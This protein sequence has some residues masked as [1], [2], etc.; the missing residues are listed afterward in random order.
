MPDQNH[1]PPKYRP[2]PK[3]IKKRE[4]IEDW[5]NFCPYCDN[6]QSDRFLYYEP[7][8]PFFGFNEGKGTSEDFREDLKNLAECVDFF[9]DFLRWIL[10]RTNEE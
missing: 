10:Y 6:A 4:H 3:T 2:I 5:V 1:H 7:D 9:D 8:G